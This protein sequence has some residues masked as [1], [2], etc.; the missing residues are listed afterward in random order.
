[1][2]NKGRHKKSLLIKLKATSYV[3]VQSKNQMRDLHISRKQWNKEN[4]HAKIYKT[5][6]AY[7]QLI[8]ISLNAFVIK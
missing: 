1:M 7:T 3:T 2:H 5:K 4:F 8:K 6:K